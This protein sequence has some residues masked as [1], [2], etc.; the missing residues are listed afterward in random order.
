MENLE[1]ENSIWKSNKSTKTNLK[2][3]QRL[4]HNFKGCL[5]V[6]LNLEVIKEEENCSRCGNTAK[7]VLIYCII[8]RER[9]IDVQTINS[10]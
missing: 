5:D 4:F 9:F 3:I 8:F 10:R 1:S 7:I 2:K 6:L